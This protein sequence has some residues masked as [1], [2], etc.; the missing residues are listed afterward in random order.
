MPVLSASDTAMMRTQASGSMGDVCAIRRPNSDFSAYSFVAVGVPC[1]VLEP[2]ALASRVLPLESVRTPYGG[3]RPVADVDRRTIE[4]PWGQDVR[5]GDK[6]Q[7]LTVVNAPVTLTGL[8]VVVTPRS[9]VGIQSGATL[10]VYDPDGSKEETV[11]VGTVTA[12]T[13]AA[14]FANTHIAGW[15]IAARVY[16]VRNLDEDYTEDWTTPVKAQR[17]SK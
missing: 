9:M 15:Y 8:P 1:D 17:V 4:L 2:E 14:T 7:A 5:Q 13:F 16:E 11:T 10:N 6:V 12:T 3:A